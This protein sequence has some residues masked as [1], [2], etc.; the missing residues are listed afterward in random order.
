MCV[1]VGVY[2][3]SRLLY[4]T[5]ILNYRLTLEA[6]TPDGPKTG[7]GV[8]QVSYGSEFNLNGG[9][10]RGVMRVTGE[11]VPVD[12]GQGKILF[13]TLT[14]N[15]SGRGG[16]SKTLAAAQ[17]AEW[18]PIRVFGFDWNWG[19]ENKL[20]SQVEAAKAAGPKDV[21][22]RALPT[23]VTFKDISDPKTVELVQPEALAAT[24]GEGYALTK[25]TTELT[26]EEPYPI[27]IVTLPWL[28]EYYDK[29]L[30]GGKYHTAGAEN[31][32]ANQ[33]GSGTFSTFK[34]EN[35]K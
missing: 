33:M 15:A 18:L 16:D 11:A 12:L 21:P 17:D 30:D 20:S 19:E 6:I 10:R 22:F 32:L 34:K 5:V 28:P 7:S 24:F 14:R 4:P 35:S 29:N 13:V 31:Q 3:C 27:I 26:D 1:V 2:A 8:V 9:G 25:A 23:L